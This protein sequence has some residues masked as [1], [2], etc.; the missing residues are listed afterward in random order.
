MTKV[1]AA[2]P[3][4]EPQDGHQQRRRR[5]KGKEEKLE[6][7][8]RAVLAAVHGDQDRHGHQRQLPEAV[9]EHQVERDEDAEHRRLLNEKERVED[10]APL[11]IAFQLA[12]TPTGASRPASTTSQRLSPSMPTW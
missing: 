10:L 6:R 8:L 1:E 11:L 5:N 2:G 3:R 4:V 9:V 12:S 7:G